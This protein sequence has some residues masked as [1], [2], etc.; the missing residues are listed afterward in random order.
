MKARPRWRSVRS[1]SP[2]EPWTSAAVES[3]ISKNRP[4]GEDQAVPGD[5]EPRVAAREAG[6]VAAK[7]RLVRA[8]GACVARG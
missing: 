8:E 4:S 3:G 7:A 6:L 5:E 1:T 2:V